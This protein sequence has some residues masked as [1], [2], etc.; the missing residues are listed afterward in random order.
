M[1]SILYTLHLLHSPNLIEVSFFLDFNIN[2]SKMFPLLFSSSSADIS[3]S[4]K[5]VRNK[6]AR[7]NKRGKWVEK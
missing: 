5:G 2:P 4:E 7:I 6:E 1:Y 3:V